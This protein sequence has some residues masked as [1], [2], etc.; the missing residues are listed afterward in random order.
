MLT[1][2]TPA[3]LV[4][5]F[6]AATATLVV[7]ALFLD[8]PGRILALGAA[9]LRGLETI[10]DALVRP[11]LTAY[12]DAL[13]IRHG[14][15]RRRISWAQ[16]EA[17]RCH[18]ARRLFVLQSLEIDLGEELIAVPG[19]RLGADPATV[20]LRLEALRSAGSYAK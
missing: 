14:L 11:T 4:V 17:V 18:E 13:V 7:V 10:R 12:A 5:G 3:R 1:Y 20:A 8:W 9:V 16:V 6:A 15:V 2:A 19:L